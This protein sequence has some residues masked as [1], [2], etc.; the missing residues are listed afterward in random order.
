ME[1]RGGMRTEGDASVI[2]GDFA[3][4]EPA[5]DVGQTS[6]V[7]QLHSKSAQSQSY[8]TQLGYDPRQ[9]SITIQGLP[10]AGLPDTE[11]PGNVG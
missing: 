7:Q 9:L 3:G 6:L 4:F 10:Y 8:T 2:V 1:C 5:G 11:M